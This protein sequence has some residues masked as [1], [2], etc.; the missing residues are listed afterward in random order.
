MVHM[1][2]YMQLPEILISALM[3]SQW[4]SGEHQQII[5]VN[6]HILCGESPRAAHALRSEES[7]PS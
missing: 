1:Q 6:C 2:W 4:D 7:P 5:N 3:R